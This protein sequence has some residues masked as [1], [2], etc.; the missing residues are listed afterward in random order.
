MK[1]QL[2]GE[3]AKAPIDL[4]LSVVKPEGARWMIAMYD[5]LKSK[6][7]IISNGFKDI[8]DCLNEL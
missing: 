3:T 7:E 6:P 4:R 8:K 5:Y 1:G 2:S